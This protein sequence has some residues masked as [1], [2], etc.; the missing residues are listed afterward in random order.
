[1]SKYLTIG[2]RN[3][4]QL[5]CMNGWRNVLFARQLF[6]CDVPSH[7]LL[8]LAW[9]ISGAHKEFIRE[10]PHPPPPVT[11]EQHSSMPAPQPVREPSFA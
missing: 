5:A 6:G 1:M 2:E 9:N 8:H 3:K 4:L 10:Y 7:D 11:A